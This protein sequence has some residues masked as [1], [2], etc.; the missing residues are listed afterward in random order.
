MQ[1]NL[2]SAEVTPKLSWEKVHTLYLPFAPLM[3]AFLLLLLAAT[4]QAAQLPHL[5]F[6]LIDDWG[7]FLVFSSSQAHT[8]YDFSA[9]WDGDA[10]AFATLFFFDPSAAY[11]M[12]YIFTSHTLI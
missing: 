11:V 6:N 9:L 7:E 1:A 12:V 3:A 10:H 4:A 5:V 2:F 8:F